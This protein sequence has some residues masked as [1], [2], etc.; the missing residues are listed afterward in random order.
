[1]FKGLRKESSGH[2]LG[3]REETVQVNQETHGRQMEKLFRRRN[4]SEET[5]QKHLSLGHLGLASLGR[6]LAWREQVQ[7]RRDRRG[8]G[9]P[10][11]DLWP[12]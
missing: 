2:I 10:G 5:F 6:E 4:F 3:W 12:A 11:P 8:Q 7:G 9:L 1:M